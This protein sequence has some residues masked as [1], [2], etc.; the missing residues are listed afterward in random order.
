[1]TGIYATSLVEADVK[2][3]EAR[4]S[5]LKKLQIEADFANQMVEHHKEKMGTSVRPISFFFALVIL[6]TLVT[7]WFDIICI[8]KESLDVYKKFVASCT[9]YDVFMSWFIGFCVC[10]LYKVKNDEKKFILEAIKLIPGF[11][12]FPLIAYILRKIEAIYLNQCIKSWKYWFT[13]IPAYCLTKGSKNGFAGHTV[14]VNNMLY[15]KAVRAYIKADMK[16]YYKKTCWK[17]NFAIARIMLYGAVLVTIHIV[18]IPL[19]LFIMIFVI[20]EILITNNVILVIHLIF[21]DMFTC[22]IIGNGKQ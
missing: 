7:R 16:K 14:F 10:I 17:R 15:P 9:A 4:K 21:P 5:F 1:M 18:N 22:T 12:L 8:Q 2:L 13:K 3:T 19:F 11:C 20:D 6:F